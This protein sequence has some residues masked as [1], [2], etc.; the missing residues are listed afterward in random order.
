MMAGSGLALFML[1]LFA[2]VAASTLTGP[3]HCLLRADTVSGARACLLRMRGGADALDELD[4]EDEDEDGDAAAVTGDDALENPF[5]GVPSSG[6]AGGA[7]GV[8]MEDLASTLGNPAALQDALKE[9]QV[10]ARS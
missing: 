1:A 9:L 3:T 6:G 4:E 2:Q 5:L 7:G 10:R 8:G